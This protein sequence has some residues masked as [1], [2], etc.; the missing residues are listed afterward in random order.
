MSTHGTRSRYVQGCRC[1]LCSQANRTYHR[2]RREGRTTEWTD[3]SGFRRLLRLATMPQ[4]T[5]Q[6]VARRTGLSLRTLY[7]IRNGVDR[8]LQP[9]TAERLRAVLELLPNERTA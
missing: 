8:R 5:M 2:A 1:G 6:D 7:D 9:G 4:L 3:P